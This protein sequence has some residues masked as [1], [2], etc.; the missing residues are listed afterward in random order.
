MRG[1]AFYAFLAKAEPTDEW[2]PAVAAAALVVNAADT[3]LRGA[4]LR[5]RE[6]ESARRH[7]AHLTLLP[8][9]SALR[10]VLELVTSHRRDDSTTS[11]VLG[12]RLLALGLMLRDSGRYSVAADVFD[13]VAGYDVVGADLVQ[14]AAQLHATAA[15][16]GALTID[17]LPAETSLTV[18]R[19]SANAS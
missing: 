18:Y 6:I 1:L 3:A 15:A 2:S 8:F 16:M 17:G 4:E 10:E 5:P 19:P 11:S 13:I 7:I 14:S 9:A 12:A